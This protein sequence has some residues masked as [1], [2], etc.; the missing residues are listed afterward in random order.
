MSQIMFHTQNLGR[1]ILATLFFAAIIVVIAVG[2]AR[3]DTSVDLPPVVTATAPTT[4]MKPTQSA[5]HDP[6]VETVWQ[7]EK[8]MFSS[9]FEDQ[10]GLLEP[11]A[12]TY[13]V[14]TYE[15]RMPS[16]DPTLRVELLRDESSTPTWESS[17][18]GKVRYVT[19]I[20]TISTYRHDTVVNSNFQLPPRFTT[21][22]QENGQWKVH[23]FT[24]WSSEP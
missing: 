23:S 4:E 16:K 12:T 18:D 13:F 22:I 7:F 14:T 21:W 8:A 1:W 10:K 2:I 11:I 19:T 3:K 6:F 20:V 15:R 24:D 5:T 17:D 9:S